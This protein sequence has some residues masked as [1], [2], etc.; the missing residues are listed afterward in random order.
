MRRALTAAVVA[1]ALV[2]GCGSSTAS[3]AAAKQ[4]FLDAIAQIRSTH[5][6]EKLHRQLL[7]TS[8]RLREIHP[9]RPAARTG[10]AL[11]LRGFRWTLR[12]LEARIE[13]RVNDSGN[14]EASVHDAK[15]ADRDL[16]RG[17]NLLRAA[18]RAFGVR[19]GTLN[20]H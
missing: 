19:V 10:R 15:R 6:A 5:S 7:R 12:G 18:G 8:A 9:R 20:G 2:P 1:L 14:L 4:A 3:D 16:N 17:A 13:I 11:A